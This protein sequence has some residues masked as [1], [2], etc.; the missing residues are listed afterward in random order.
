MA[1]RRNPSLSHSS[2][3]TSADPH[4]GAPLGATLAPP[5]ATPTAPR[6]CA[7]PS[8][9][10]TSI[11]SPPCAWPPQPVARGAV[12]VALRKKRP[13]H[14]HTTAPPRPPSCRS[15]STGT[16]AVVFH[17]P[18]TGSTWCR[19]CCAEEMNEPRATPSR[20]RAR[21]RVGVSSGSA[22]ASHGPCSMAPQLVVRACRQCCAEEMNDPTQHWQRPPSCR[23]QFRFACRIAWAVLH[24]PT[25][26]ST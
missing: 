21:R 14:P 3:R 26:G 20:H 1:T 13:P 17:G 11:G 23:S 22:V 5:F 24:G 7:P 16:A 10:S 15:P 12:N 25:T 4:V 18:T 2:T 19:Q 9:R 6:C 8:V